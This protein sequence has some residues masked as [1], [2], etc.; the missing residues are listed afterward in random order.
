M[1]KVCNKFNDYYNDE[2]IKYLEDEFVHKGLKEE[3]D[4]KNKERKQV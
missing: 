3:Y 2:T 1:H 4:K